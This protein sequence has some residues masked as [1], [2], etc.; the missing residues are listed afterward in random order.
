MSWIPRFGLSGNSHIDKVAACV[1]KVL[2]SALDS[3]PRSELPEILGDMLKVARVRV[4]NDA[5]DKLES[6]IVYFADVYREKPDQTAD[7]MFSV[8]KGFLESV[9]RYCP[10]K[11]K[12]VIGEI[13]YEIITGGC[14]SNKATRRDMGSNDKAVKQLAIRADEA[15]RHYIFDKIMSMRSG[16]LGINEPTDTY[17]FRTLVAQRPPGSLSTKNLAIGYYKK[18]FAYANLPISDKLKVIKDVLEKN[19]TEDVVMWATAMLRYLRDMSPLYELVNDEAKKALIYIARYYYRVER[20]SLCPKSD[21]KAFVRRNTN[22]PE[23]ES[24]LKRN[25]GN[26]LGVLLDDRLDSFKYF[27]R[28]LHFSLVNIHNETKAQE[29]SEELPDYLKRQ[30]DDP[31]PEVSEPKAPEVYD[32]GSP[33]SPKPSP[34]SPIP[35]HSPS[36]SPEPS[37][38]SPK[39]TSVPDEVNT[40]KTGVNTKGNRAVDE[41]R[42]FYAREHAR[43]AEQRA[44]DDAAGMM[45]QQPTQQ[46]AGKRKKT[47]D[48]DDDVP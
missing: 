11:F 40:K 22:N 18:V 48:D 14:V 37:S 1:A 20:N 3:L 15:I 41:S 36:S 38:S 34:S 23:H 30:R 35:S 44:S 31:E 7:D 13:C 24:F 42:A 9:S 39:N 4:N 25:K 5:R 8:V 28:S 21:A 16:D 17:I 19:K 33:E 43:D 6:A 26:S 27:N 29:D 10:K 46:T 32:D 2:G 12:P 45:R 47:L